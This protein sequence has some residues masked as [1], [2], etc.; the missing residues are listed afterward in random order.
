MMDFNA[1]WMGR[2]LKYAAELKPIYV[3]NARK[4]V[5]RINMLL[6]MFCED[7]GIIID[8][9]ASGWRPPEVND[10][11]SNAAASSTHRTGEGGDIRDKNRAFAAWCILHKEALSECGLY[12]EDPRWTPTWVHL[13]THPPASGKLV[14]IP[15]TKPALASALPGQTPNRAI[16]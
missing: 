1:Y 10:A 4:L 9:W 13:Q 15:S 16:V 7:T 11:T 5:A 3:S 6:G 14:Y 8:T 12:M 2:D